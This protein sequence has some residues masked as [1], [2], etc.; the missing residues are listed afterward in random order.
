MRSAMAITVRNEPSAS[1][2]QRKSTKATPRRFSEP[3]TSGSVESSAKTCS[4]WVRR[5]LSM[6]ASNSPSL[7]SK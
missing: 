6:M 2:W 1:G 7:L 3:S 4:A 5:S